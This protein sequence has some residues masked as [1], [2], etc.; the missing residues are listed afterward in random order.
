MRKATRCEWCCW[1]D[2]SEN[3]NGIVV[4]REYKVSK[5]ME[6]GIKDAELKWMT[7]VIVVV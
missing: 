3:E 5:R 6:R 1:D 4:Q 7:T 2:E